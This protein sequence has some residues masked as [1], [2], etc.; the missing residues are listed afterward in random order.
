M[1]IALLE[2]LA[3]AAIIVVSGIGT[4]R[5][6]D[7]ISRVTG[8][9]HLL[10]GAL[11]VATATSRR[12]CSSASMPLIKAG[13]IWRWRPTRRGSHQ[14]AGL[15]GLDMLKP[16]RGVAAFGLIYYLG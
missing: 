16:S 2:F 11:L 9:G 10:G 12:T 5:A 3:S 8:L 15:A 1:S 13:S 14:H 7:T 6:A 4:A